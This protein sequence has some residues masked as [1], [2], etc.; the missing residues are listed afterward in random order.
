MTIHVHVFFEDFSH[1]IY[2]C[3]IHSSYCTEVFVLVF[4]DVPLYFAYFCIFDLFNALVCT[5]Y[6]FKG[7]FHTQGP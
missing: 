1:L 6:L 5:F 4:V 2:A 7:S 3:V